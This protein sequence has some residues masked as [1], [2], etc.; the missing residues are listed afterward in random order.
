MTSPVE[1]GS[2]F[3]QFWRWFWMN[4]AHDI[5]PMLTKALFILFVAGVL[6]S[7]VQN[8]INSQPCSEFANT[9]QQDVPLRC[10]PGYKP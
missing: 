3:R 10:L 1:H 6:I 2:I 9:R 5:G 8:K 4:P 7:L